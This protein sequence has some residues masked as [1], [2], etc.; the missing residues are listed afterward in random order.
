MRSTAAI[1]P[2]E[3]AVV[4]LLAGVTTLPLVSL[5]I[6]SSRRSTARGEERLG[7]DCSARKSGLGLTVLRHKQL[8]L[9]GNKLA[10]LQVADCVFQLVLPV[11]M[12]Y[13]P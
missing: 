11:G 12:R 13:G 1:S 4:L 10:A 7:Y 3:I 9:C 5:A 6:C 8:C 2:M